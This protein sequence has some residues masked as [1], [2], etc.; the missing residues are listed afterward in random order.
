LE[1]T[2]MLIITKAAQHMMIFCHNESKKQPD[3]THA[4]G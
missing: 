1:W 4:G 3:N 2:I